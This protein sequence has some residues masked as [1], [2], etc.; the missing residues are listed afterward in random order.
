MCFFGTLFYDFPYNIR[1]NLFIISSLNTQQFYDS[2]YGLLTVTYIGSIFAKAANLHDAA[3][4]D[5]TCII[6]FI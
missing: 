4:F 3:A 6:P 2:I 5:I 1:S